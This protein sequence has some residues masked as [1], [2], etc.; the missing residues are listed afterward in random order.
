M[1]VERWN[2][3]V[4]ISYTYSLCIIVYNDNWHNMMTATPG[5]NIT[6]KTFNIGQVGI[7][8]FIAIWA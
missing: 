2:I 5:N 1:E 7:V 3:V 6:E 8:W 4:T